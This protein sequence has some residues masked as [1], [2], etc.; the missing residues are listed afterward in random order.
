MTGLIIVDG[1]GT[2][3]TVSR[4]MPEYEVLPTGGLLQT[5]T[6][7]NQWQS[8]QR[9][10]EAIVR[11]REAVA[12]FERVY[13]IRDGSREGEL[14]AEQVSEN[15][16]NGRPIWTLLVS[17]LT[18]E[19]IGSALK[20]PVPIDRA[21]SEAAKRAA[22]LEQTIDAR[23]S[24]MIDFDFHRHGLEMKPNGIGVT[25]S[26]ALQMIA[27]NQDEI[28]AYVP[29]S[30][31]QIVVNY[32]KGG[33]GFDAVLKS[34]YMM[35]DA[36]E[37]ERMISELRFNEHRIV[38]FR[39]K[40]K[41]I[42]PYPP[43]SASRLARS[44]F[45][46]FGHKPKETK[47]IARSLFEKGL[48]TDPMSTGISIS[49]GA[50]DEIVAYLKRTV[51]PE[52]IVDNK[53]S[54]VKRKRKKRQEGEAE[55]ERPEFDPKDLKEAI[56]PTAFDEGVHPDALAEE[57]SAEE[58]KLYE[59]IWYRTI[60]T[61]MAPS[62]Y[63]ASMA[64][65]Q[66]GEDISYRVEAHRC[67]REGWQSLKGVMLHESEQ[68]TDEYAQRRTQSIPHFEIDEEIVPLEVGTVER[69]TRAPGRYGVGRFITTV[70]NFVRPQHLDRIVNLLEER[71]YII[72]DSTGM[73]NITALGKKV[74]HWTKHRASWLSDAV[75]AAE[76]KKGLQSAE[77]GDNDDIEFL[78]EIIL[79]NM[80]MLEKQIDY[81]PRHLR[82]P[83]EDEVRFARGIANRLGKSEEE[84]DEI[85]RTQKA[86]LAFIEANKKPEL[87]ACPECAS[88]GRVGT[89][90][91]HGSFLGCSS[92]KRGCRF[93]MNKQKQIDYLTRSGHRTNEVELVTILKALFGN[94]KVVL[95]FLRKRDGKAQELQVELENDPD[96]GWQFKINYKK[97]KRRAA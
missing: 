92:H 59:F 10:Q 73:I 75:F 64:E 35:E 46:L 27:A 45:Y 66:V 42:L 74:A 4:L 5:L 22:W 50:F 68:E 16:M 72:V 83:T 81:K 89:V 37:M 84:I 58:L 65:I 93:S 31:D 69:K 33:V 57:L 80:D 95:E 78:E 36:E 82:A 9:Q 53:R 17:E 85:T 90:I 38:K 39:P 7:E 13:F 87:G 1:A 79:S 71:K 52:D 51:S 11:L 41:Q 26:P 97:A 67:M 3:S 23:M 34:R 18:I 70:E 19:A 61:Q 62:I 8:N 29:E 88:K 76:F 60:T 49:D 94:E 54:F 44:S 6:A 24:D 40:T 28:D 20:H 14:L 21:M 91:D 63:D 30:Y 55:E 86:C 43:L 12:A 56:R 47:S 32:A 77:Q 2:A 96:W 48:I 15:V 25:V